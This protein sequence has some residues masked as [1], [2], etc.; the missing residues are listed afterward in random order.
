MR[1]PMLLLS[2][3]ILSL[4]ARTQV[5]VSEEPRHHKVLAN[6]W[7][8]VL[9]VHV[10]P[11][12]TTQMHK[13]STP[14]VF[15]V[16]SNTRTGSQVLVEPGKP[17]FADGNIW[18]ESFQDKPR[19]HRVWNED[20]V[21]FHVMDIELPHVPGSFGKVVDPPFSKLLFDAKP[22]RVYRLTLPAGQ[23]EALPRSQAPILVISLSG[24]G[25]NGTVNR[26]P[27]TKK[28]DYLFLSGNSPVAIANNSPTDDQ[29]FAVLY[30][31]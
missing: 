25:A 6:E 7:V 3:L 19:I 28:G 2:G 16:L 23:H 1:K 4:A 5:Q 31:K 17:S 10:P 20:T 12:D 14:S 30:L 13:H 21:E 27:F 9:D 29:Q 15:I 26:Q 11:H 8:R 18:F 24:P 22:A